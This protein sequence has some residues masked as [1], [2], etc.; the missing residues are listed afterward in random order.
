MNFYHSLSSYILDNTTEKIFW[1]RV[2]YAK[3]IE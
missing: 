1:R 2:E 3:K